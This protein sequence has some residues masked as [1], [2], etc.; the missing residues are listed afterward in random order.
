VLNNG[1]SS[2]DDDDNVRD[3]SCAY[4]KHI[5][6]ID[7]ISPTGLGPFWFLRVGCMGGGAVECDT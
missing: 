6:T 7:V 3:V 1:S 4:V 5:S 2:S